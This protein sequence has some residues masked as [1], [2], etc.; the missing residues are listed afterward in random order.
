MKPSKGQLLETPGSFTYRLDRR[1]QRRA[2]LALLSARQRELRTQAAEALLLGVFSWALLTSTWPV[3]LV[4][5]A[6][7][8][9]VLAAAYVTTARAIARTASTMPSATLRFD[10]DALQGCAIDT[11]A[12]TSVDYGDIT[13]LVVT[14]DGVLIQTSRLDYLYLPA[15]RVDRSLLRFLSERIEA[16]RLRAAPVPPATAV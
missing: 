15:E 4:V 2:T 12:Y 16:A 14:D 3:A 5:L 10:G 1:Q 6:Y 8:A 9:N 7:V 11:G 13:R